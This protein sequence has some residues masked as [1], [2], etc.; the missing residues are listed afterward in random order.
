M[1]HICS[2]RSVVENLGCIK[3]KVLPGNEK[4]ESVVVFDMPAEIDASVLSSLYRF[5]RP[6]ESNAAVFFRDIRQ[7]QALFLGVNTSGFPAQCAGD[8][9]Q[10]KPAKR[11]NVVGGSCS[12]EDIEDSLHALQSAEDGDLMTEDCKRGIVILAIAF[13]A[14]R[15]N[16]IF[17]VRYVLACVEAGLKGQ[18]DQRKAS[19]ML[20]WKEQLLR[21]I[22]FTTHTLHSAA[23]DKVIVCELSRVV[24]R[25]AVW[26]ILSLR[27]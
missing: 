27:L 12:L 25:N 26:R 23:F 6:V 13:V 3:S 24:L 18:G 11:C 9:Y 16:T 7:Q 19:E 21:T 2:R 10:K 14:L 17:L 1:F 15:E 22:S 5:E 8:F 20:R 4:F